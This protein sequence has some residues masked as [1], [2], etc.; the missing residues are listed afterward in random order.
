M[1]GELHNVRWNYVVPDPLAVR[2]VLAE[3]FGIVLDEIRVLRGLGDPVVAQI[4]AIEDVLFAFGHGFDATD[5][6]VWSL[7]TCPVCHHLV[8]QGLPS[9]SRFGLALNAATGEVCHHRQE[10]SEDTALLESLT[11]PFHPLAPENEDN[12]A[13]RRGRNWC[14]GV[15]S[16]VEVRSLPAA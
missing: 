11:R 6:T 1:D 9:C 8:A 15:D 13:L 7:V 10:S 16:H 14:P 5:A 2:Q 12:L 3:Y 4:V